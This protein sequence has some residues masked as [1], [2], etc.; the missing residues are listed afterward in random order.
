[1]P[2]FSVRHDHYFHF[3]DGS[4]ALVPLLEKIMADIDDVRATVGEIKTKLTE[5]S[6]ELVTL[7][8]GLQT[9]VAELEA[10]LG[11]VPQDIKD[12]LETAKGIATS[13]ADVVP[14]EPPTE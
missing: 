7:V 11:E 6:S 1:M 4:S 9:K 14:N 10:R 13:L 12:D 5:A 3:E 8:T 2:I